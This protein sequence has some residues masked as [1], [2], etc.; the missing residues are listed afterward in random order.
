MT[1]YGLPPYVNQVSSGV[2]YDRDQGSS[3]LVASLFSVSGGCGEGE[4]HVAPGMLDLRFRS[5]T[6][7]M[8]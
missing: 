4:Y 2:A 3:L 7:V 6:I 1:S 5:D 8:K